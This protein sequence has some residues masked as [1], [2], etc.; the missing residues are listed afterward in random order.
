MIEIYHTGWSDDTCLDERGA[1]S[2]ALGNQSG[3]PG[4]TYNSI[5]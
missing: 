3:K 1:L 5:T 4:D 2:D